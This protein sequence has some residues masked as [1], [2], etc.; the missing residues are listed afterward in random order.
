MRCE[1]HSALGIALGHPRVSAAAVPPPRE[2][3][4]GEIWTDG[5]PSMQQVLRQQQLAPAARWSPVVSSTAPDPF[6]AA[7]IVVGRPANVAVALLGATPA[8]GGD[9]SRATNV[10]LP[11]RARSRPTAT[12]A[13][14]A[15]GHGTRQI[16]RSA[17]YVC[18][19]CGHGLE[20]GSY[21]EVFGESFV[22]MSDLCRRLAISR[23]PRSSGAGAVFAP[24]APAGA[25]AS[26]MVG[27]VVKIARQ[28][29]DGALLTGAPGPDSGL[30]RRGL[31]CTAVG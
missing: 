21:G 18:L 30:H 12:T 23:A 22:H 11:A 25:Q 27:D 6:P 20:L 29:S 7:P 19:G 31:L 13:R 17:G 16:V 4:A 5:L 28:W 15:T 14:S 24:S 1:P 10:S 2:M 3:R 26:A 9:L 8:L